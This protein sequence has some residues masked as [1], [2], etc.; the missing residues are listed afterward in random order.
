M[1]KALLQ[2]S[3][4]LHDYPS[5][6]QHLLSNISCQPGGPYHGPNVGNAASERLR[7]CPSRDETSAKEFM[8]RLLCPSVNIGQVIGKGGEILNQIRQDSRAYIKVDSYY[9][10][11]DFTISISAK[12]VRVMYTCESSALIS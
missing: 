12:E 7:T 1:K 5:Q 10:D 11:D 9:D 6:L 2:V 3:F 4:R 8:L